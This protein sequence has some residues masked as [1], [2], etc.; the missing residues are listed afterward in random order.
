MSA[1]WGVGEEIT[2]AV[3]RVLVARGP[4]SEDNLLS[5]LAADGV[6]LGP[7]PQA[8]LTEVLD[9]D[10]EPFMELADQRW[11]WLPGLL[12]GRI[13]THRLSAVEAAHD[14]I[15][16]GVDLEPV[17]MLTDY[18]TYQR[19]SD[20]S[21]ISEVCPL[22]GGDVDDNDVL[23]ARGVPAAAVDS[24]TAV[25]VLPAGRF[26]ALG[27]GAGDLVGLRVSANGLE[28]VAVRGE[29]QPCGTGAALGGLLDEHPDRPEMLDVAVWTVCTDDDHLF[30]EAAAPLGELL[31]ASGLA[32][33][34]GWIARSGFDFAGWRV[35]G[36]VA[37]IQERYELEGDEA[38]AVLVAV[39]LYEQTL[40]LVE[41]VLDTHEDSD[42]PDLAGIVSQL[43]PQADLTSGQVEHKPDRDGVQQPDTHR[44]TVRETLEFLADPGVTTAVLA[45]TGDDLFEHDRRSAIALGVFAESAEPLAPRGARPALR[46]LRAKAHE[47]L[48]DIEEAEVSL[49]GAE[50]LDPWWPLTL[51]SLAQYASDRGDA[52]RGLSLLRRA[53][54][55]TDHHLVALLEHFRPT[56]RPDLGRNERCWC[57]SGRKYKVCHLHREQL[58]LEDRAAWLYQ[59]AGT[60]LRHEAGPFGAMLIEAALTR[61]RYWEMPGGLA[62]ALDDPLACDV[63]L[64]EGGAFADFLNVRGPLLPE[65]ERLLAG[66]WLLVDRSVYEV[67][68]VARGRGFTVRDVRTG[69][70]HEVRER[71]G[72]TQVSTGQFYCL[73]VVPAGDTMQIFGGIEPVSLAERD[74][75]IALLDDDDL[76]PIELVAA[77]SRRFAPPVLR[78]TEGEPLMMCDA[79]L[80]VD[81]PAMLARALDDTYHRDDDQPDDQP[82]GTLVWYEHVI[83]HGMQRIRAH[84]DLRGDHLHVHANS[85]TRFERVL[86]T[87][88]ALDPSVTVLTETR[89]P[90]GDMQAVQQL[91]ARNPAPPS[92]A[93]DPT[94][95]PDIAAALET[96]ARQYETAWLDEPIPALANHTPR[97]C[98]HDPTRRPDLIR[99][100]DSFPQD[101]NRPG[102][103]SPTRLRAALG[104]N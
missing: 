44:Q 83:T 3:R 38:L 66:Q 97:Q 94:T 63:V 15:E 56:P 47:R 29:P 95:D 5:A 7:E 36:R 71:A 92:P 61:A 60:H 12:E 102:A 48:G 28:L 87:V 13:F 21:P 103:M 86:A 37:T 43:P 20:G 96:M 78:N 35:A 69:D 16:S 10:S 19:L 104:L 88:R 49:L 72:S 34:G 79:T 54:A 52:E 1:A 53:G 82:D 18:E 11:A 90:A 100:L 22:H 58:R 2:A 65:D 76:D 50:S 24:D 17:A 26:A 70:V 89:E 41:T 59:K 62:R 81:D 14:I 57:G 23:T 8:M 55:P 68:A 99:L 74:T 80:R 84:L 32:C 101:N 30:R 85:T 9:Q 51:L 46:W 27:V 33:E 64:F 42:E 40:D 73:R 39:R 31:S 6:D 25:L 91:A 4:M 67:L 93:L 98:A 75:L 77:L 45:E